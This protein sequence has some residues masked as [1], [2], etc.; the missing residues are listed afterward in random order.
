[1]KVNLHKT[2]RKEKFRHCWIP[3]LILKFKADPRKCQQN[4]NLEY[5]GLTWC[6]WLVKRKKKLESKYFFRILLLYKDSTKDERK[7]FKNLTTCFWQTVN[8]FCCRL[9]LPITS[10]VILLQMRQEL[11]FQFNFLLHLHS[12]SAKI[13]HNEGF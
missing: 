4:C 5:L 8:W 9:S 2:K 3:D 1:M 7:S 11:N 10:N 12:L 6:C 13:V